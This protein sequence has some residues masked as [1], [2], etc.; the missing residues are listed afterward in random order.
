[1]S[2]FSELIPFFTSISKPFPNPKFFLEQYCT[3]INILR[4]YFDF[5]P[6]INPKIVLD[7]GSGTGILSFLALKK[8]ASQVIG[9]DIDHESLKTAKKSAK[10]WDISNLSLIHSSIEFFNFQKFRN[11]IAGVI[12]NPPFGTKRKFLDF[13]FLKQAMITKG[14][15]LTL[16]KNNDETNKKLQTLCSEQ[17]YTIKNARKLQ[18]IIPNTH[19]SHKKSNYPVEVIL[20]LLVSNT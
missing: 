8:N 17:E 2:E 7:L 5:F 4:H 20:Y 1:M 18:F 13:V 16:H 14:W 19:K 11:N 3:N 6:E 15:I 9:I 10:S 12:M